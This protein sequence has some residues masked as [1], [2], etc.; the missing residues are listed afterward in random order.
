MQHIDIIS[1]VPSRFENAL[2]TGDLFF[3]PSTIE[4][5]TEQ[6]IQYEIR[7]CPALQHKPALPTPH[8]SDDLIDSEITDHTPKGKKFDPF[9]PPYN[10]NLHV[11]DLKD[12]V[13][14]EEFAILLNKYSVVPQH[15][16]M[17]TKEFRSQA[18]PLMPH[19]LLQSYT[20]VLS[21]RKIGK[22][23]FA[24]YNCGN[25]SGASQ[26]H[27]HIQFVPIEDDGPPIERLARQ[28]K[29]DFADRPFSLTKLSYAS[30]SYRFPTNLDTYPQE[31][32]EEL[33]ANAFLQLLDLSI[34]TIRHDPEYP[35]GT[36]SYNVIM[37]LE[38][39]HIV[40]RR[41]EHY[42]LEKTGEK[43][44][45][46]ALGFAGMLLVKSDEELAAVKREGVGKILRGV[47]LSSVHDIQVEGQMD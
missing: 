20:M 31:R 28:A 22:K 25:N 47:G 7:L 21:A 24:F 6:E 39:L 44:N 1:A 40:P 19:E 15:F 27:K 38:H 32:L 10:N 41:L 46:N 2:K 43:L 8:F 13:S 18:S 17:V 3:F 42:T 36:P 11:G 37:T 16:L 35:A 33:L 26:P 5:H 4:K 30:H 34:S 9:L 29:L 14:Q 12:E 45:I 23:I